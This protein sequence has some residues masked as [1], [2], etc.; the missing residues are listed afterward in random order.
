ME[1]EKNNPSIKR[2]DF[3]S[4]TDTCIFT[5]A[6]PKLFEYLDVLSQVFLALKQATVSSRSDSSSEAN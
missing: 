6:K 1:K 2:I 4:I 5:T 3:S